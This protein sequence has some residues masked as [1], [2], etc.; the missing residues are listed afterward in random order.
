MDKEGLF[1]VAFNQ[2]CQKKL[3]RFGMAG[4]VVCALETK[5]GNIFTGICLLYWFMCRTVCYC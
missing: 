2:I 1:Q 3:R 5:K 4:H